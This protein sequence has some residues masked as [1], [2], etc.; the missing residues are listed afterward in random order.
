MLAGLDR[1]GT[2]ELLAVDGIDAHP[3][4]ARRAGHPQGRAA[5]TRA[6]SYPRRLS[7]ASIAYYGAMQGMSRMRAHTRVEVS[8]SARHAPAA[9]APRP[10]G[11]P[12]R[13]ESMTT[14]LARASSIDPANIVLRRFRRTRARRWRRS[15]LR[16]KFGC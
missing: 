11:F 16:E 12:A 9:G 14:A 13:A 3:R 7:R 1:A 4:A 10:E 5:W 15:A 2:A 6:A 8:R